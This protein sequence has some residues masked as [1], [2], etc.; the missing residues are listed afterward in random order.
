M[1]LTE[2][3]QNMFR[4]PNTKTAH[5]DMIIAEEALPKTTPS[6]HNR[7]FIETVGRYIKAIKINYWKTSR[8]FHDSR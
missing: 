1:K 3:Y 4:I 8:I 7:E 5:G 2:G 6:Q